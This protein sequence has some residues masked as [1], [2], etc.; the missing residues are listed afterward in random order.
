MMNKKNKVLLS[1]VGLL[2]LSGIA[3]TS[4]TFAWFTTVRSAT[5]NYSEATASTSSGNLN[6]AFKESENNAIQTTAPVAVNNVLDLTGFNNIITDISGDGATFYK[7]VWADQS[8]NLQQD[9]FIASRIDTVSTAD[10]N[11]VD[12]TITISRD[13]PGGNG[14]HVYL[15]SGTEFTKTADGTLGGDI[16]PALR[17]AVLDSSSNVKV[18][19]AP[20][21]EANPKYLKA[22]GSGTAYGNGATTGFVLE[23][24][25]DLKSGAITTHTDIDDANDHGYHVADLSVAVSADVTFRVWIE[26]TDAQAVNAIIGGKFKLD[27]DLYA[28]EVVA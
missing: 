3:A 19:W 27:I 8:D 2:L 24:D 13:N 25:S 11:Y 23:T 16:V 5:V 17:L 10:S 9:N 4:S 15:G 21:A 6:I 7:P 18:R 20:E 14:Y 26:G 12:F 1:T 28:L 22:D